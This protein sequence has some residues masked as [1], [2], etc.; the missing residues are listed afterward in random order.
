MKVLIAEDNAFSCKLL[1]KTLE[2]AGYTAVV[3]EDGDAAW[4]VMQTE[5]AP[6]MVL[7]D[8]MM[9]GLQGIEVCERIRSLERTVPPYIIMLTAKADRDD[10][11]QGFEAGADDY[12]KKPYDSS[13]L[14]A[15]MKVGARLV[16][17]QA[18]M[19]SLIDALP[20]PIYMKDSRGLYL[21]CNDAYAA[22]AGIDKDQIGQKQATDVLPD[23]Q[24][25]KT[26]M[27]DLRALAADEPIESEEW[28]VDADGKNVCHYSMRVPLMES[29][30]GL[31]GLLV[32]HRDVS[33]ESLGEKQLRYQHKLSVLGSMLS[34]VS[35][36]FKNII[37]AIMG[38]ASLGLD[39]VDKENEAYEYL[40]DIHASGEGAKKLLEKLLDFSNK[41]NQEMEL[42]VLSDVV[43]DSL[44]LVRMMK[45]PSVAL[46]FSAEAELPT[47]YGD[48]VQLQQV[49]TNLC[50]NA[51]YAMEGRESAVLTL[52][53]ETALAKHSDEPSI[54]FSV[55]D[56][57]CG[58][59]VA[60]QEDIFEPHF[61]T[62]EGEGSGLG[63]SIVKTIVEQHQGTIE[64]ESNEGVGSC[65]RLRFPAKV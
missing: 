12:L 36:E 41:E 16:Q 52:R 18:L 53:V 24:A 17:Q 3:A 22:F 43:E 34:Y 23:A 28:T 15:R 21:G 39:S 9:P 11:V 31:R 58:I 26:H 25:Y 48:R 27:D 20:D 13:E 32:L 35:H 1:V 8:W 60:A 33:H 50:V 5:Q 63:L 4:S 40:D 55:E 44:G 2:K 65:F 14:L 56:S 64:V 29:S 45:A 30:S 51:L 37:N 42:L 61:T 38:F 62:R 54:L 47:M 49:V 59:P 57:G 19:H 7:L 6:S 10:V 46:E